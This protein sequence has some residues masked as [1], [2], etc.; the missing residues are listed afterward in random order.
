MKKMIAF[1]IR[2]TSGSGK[3]TLAESLACLASDSIICEADDYFIDAD[4]NYNFDPNLLGQAHSWCKNK[5]A[6]AVKNRVQVVICS[7]TNTTKK[8]YQFYID[9]AKNAGYTVHIITVERFMNTKSIHEVP[10]EV[11]QK[12]S[13]RLRSSMQF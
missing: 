4:G 2:G 3:S 1:I 13:E 11:V 12:Q 8:E 9:K 5:F 10:D 6:E 7:N